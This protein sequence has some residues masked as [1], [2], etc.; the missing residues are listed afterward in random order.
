[1]LHNIFS[2]PW[3]ADNIDELTKVLC[4]RFQPDL[5]FSRLT[6]STTCKS[7]VRHPAALNGNPL[8]ILTP[9]NTYK[10]PKNI[11]EKLL[12]EIGLGNFD[13]AKDI[14]LTDEVKSI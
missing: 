2:I 3:Y 14:N 11:F 4:N 5:N 7:V 9:S 12:A 8:F 6:N 10:E 1:M 13:T